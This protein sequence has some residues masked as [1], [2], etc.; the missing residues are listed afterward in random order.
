MIVSLSNARM[1]GQL[2]NQERKERVAFTTRNVKLNAPPRKL[3]QTLEEGRFGFKIKKESGEILI[4]F[5]QEM[6]HFP[7]KIRNIEGQR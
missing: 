3:F 2:R 4:R 5:L 7:Q 1:D 6:T